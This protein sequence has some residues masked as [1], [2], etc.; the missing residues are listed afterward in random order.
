MQN[1]SIDHLI[2]YS[3]AAED[4][5]REEVRLPPFRLVPLPPSPPGDPPRALVTTSPAAPMAAAA[6][7]SGAATISAPRLPAADTAFRPSCVPPPWL[8][9]PPCVLSSTLATALRASAITARAC[10]EVSVVSRVE[11]QAIGFSRLP[12]E[13]DAERACV[14][15]RDRAV[16]EVEP[17]AVRDPAEER[18][19]ARTAWDFVADREPAIALGCARLVAPV[20]FFVADREADFGADFCDAVRLL[21]GWEVSSFLVRAMVILS[22]AGAASRPYRGVVILTHNNDSV[23]VR[24]V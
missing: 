14:V 18:A 20:C 15:D 11:S 13:R 1:R 5:F 7:S 3:P 6:T 16:P 22:S 17:A 21:P 9:S 19:F 23:A 2:G 4:F 12:C 24:F 10:G 8:C